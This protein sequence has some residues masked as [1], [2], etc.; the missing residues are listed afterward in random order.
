MCAPA[1]R[2]KIYAST[3]HRH[4]QNGPTKNK[5]TWFPDG[6]LAGGRRRVRNYSGFAANTFQKTIRMKSRSQT[7][8]A[9]FDT[10][11][12]MN[13]KSADLLRASSDR[14]SQAATSNK[15]RANEQTN[16]DADRRSPSD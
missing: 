13:K 1:R 3:F 5:T 16:D 4:F 6:W 7:D 11:V 9:I 2:P 14:K 12:I 10:W 15:P 8:T